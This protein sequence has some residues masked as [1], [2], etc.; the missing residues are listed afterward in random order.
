MSCLL[1][2]YDAPDITRRQSAAHD[3]NMSSLAA[4]RHLALLHHQ[5]PHP[6]HHR[7]PLPLAAAGQASSPWPYLYATLV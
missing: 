2:C 7:L 3:Y 4:S 6:I 1:P 5:I